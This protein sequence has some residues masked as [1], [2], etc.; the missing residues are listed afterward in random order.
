MQSV[1]SEWLKECVRGHDGV[2]QTKKV[3]WAQCFVPVFL[4]LDPESGANVTV[5]AT[6]KPEGS[7]WW[8]ER[9]YPRCV[10]VSATERLGVVGLYDPKFAGR[11]WR[12]GVEAN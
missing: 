11:E 10:V 12:H 2:C 5:A 4:V 6:G 9:E 8:L 1:Y 7:K 3:W